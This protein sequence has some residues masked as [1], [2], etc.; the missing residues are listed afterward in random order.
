MPARLFS[1]IKNSLLHVLLTLL[2]AF[3]LLGCS[4][5]GPGPVRVGI[6]HSLSG[7]MAGSERPVVDAA[8][9]AIQELNEKGGV[10]GRRIEPVV[11]DGKSDTA[12]F[13][14]EAERLIR[15][16]GVAAIFGVWTSA[17]RKAVKN[18]VEEYD[19]LLF[20][21]LQYEGIEQSRNIIYLG[22]TP[23][24]QIIPAV[25]WCYRF[26]G[27]RMFLVGSD[28]VFPRIAN[29]IIR[30]ELAEFGVDAVGEEYVP[31]GSV[32]FE[33][34]VQKILTS[35]PDVILNTL[36]G[37]S[38]RAFFAALEAAGI[39]AN[40]TPV[41]SFSVGESEL[42]KLGITQLAGNYSAWSYFQSIDSSTNRG[43]LERF[44]SRFARDNVIG[45]PMQA[46]Y[47]GVHLWAKAVESAGSFKPGD[48]KPAMYD[49]SFSTA[50][51]TVRIDSL[52]QHLWQIARI[53]RFRKDGQFEIIWESDILPPVNYP[54]TRARTAWEKLL[55]ELYRG[56]G[57]SW[58]SP[59]KR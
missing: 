4:A 41:M 11:A 38:N 23:N 7:T 2:I 50:R 45:D 33:T 24:Q 47:M 43:F 17:H 28:Y 10:L 39:R 13:V 27:P 57:G 55:Q 1:I 58:I 49:K 14:S 46:S 37:D 48:V 35:K 51:G 56:W 16:E 34:V 6:L 32:D 36:N 54:A 53:G 8:L 31:L 12:V 5:S 3:F 9:F 42:R 59:K 22:P 26:I 25:E 44:Q 18:I 20:Y 29:I 19:S 21:P 15:D 52:N 40:V 30:D